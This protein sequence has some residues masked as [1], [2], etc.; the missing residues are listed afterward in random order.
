MMKLW[1]IAR[2]EFLAMVATRAFWITMLLAPV[3]MFGSLALLPYSTSSLFK[4]GKTM[5]N[6]PQTDKTQGDKGGAERPAKVIRIADGTGNLGKILIEKFG[7]ASQSFKGSSDTYQL[8][9]IEQKTLDD[10]TRRDL[11]DSIRNG[12]LHGFIEIPESLLDP[13][14]IPEARYVSRDFFVSMFMFIFQ[15]T[16]D[17]I[18]ASSV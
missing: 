3:L 9:L 18:V 16:I 12:S 7:I 1:A 2:R 5:M 13:G 10:E 8:E 14:V 6:L 15:S 17:S 11:I 4:V